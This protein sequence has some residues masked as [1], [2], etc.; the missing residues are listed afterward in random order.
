M[1]LIDARPTRTRKVKIIPGQ[2]QT[3]T[4]NTFEILVK[5]NTLN[6]T[7]AIM[8]KLILDGTQNQ[9]RL[10]NNPE[11]LTVDGSD[12]K[13]MALVKKNIIVTFQDSVPL[14]L[15]DAI[16]RNL[17]SFIAAA[18]VVDD[19]FFGDSFKGE[20]GSQGY[21]NRIGKISAWEW[22]F[23][24]PK[25]GTKV[26]SRKARVADPRAS[27]SFPQDSVW[28]LK[29]APG[30]TESGVAN[31]ATFWMT[32]RAAPKSKGGDS[33]VRVTSRSTTKR[34][35]IAQTTASVKRLKSA[36]TVTIWGGYTKK[37]P[38]QGEQ[39]FPDWMW[40]VRAKAGVDKL[41]PYIMIKARSKRSNGNK[42][43]QTEGQILKRM[44][45]QAYRGTVQ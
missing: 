42:A 35:F 3:M 30:N 37:Y 19:K 22:V 6:D 24:P 16:E 41:T 10:G 26:G 18:P 29:P 21:K 32:D 4:T 23:I 38:V 9:M 7:R 13:N 31:V 2:S 25:N 8:N 1:S 14:E 28:V 34:G 43:Y 20:N 36:R 45:K 17:M 5:S 40:K 15:I 11:R 33:G 44:A 39:W 12:T 27:T